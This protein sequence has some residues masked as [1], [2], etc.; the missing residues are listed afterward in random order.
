MQLEPGQGFH[1]VRVHGGV[2]AIAPP[3]PIVLT[4]TPAETLEVLANWLGVTKSSQDPIKRFRWASPQLCCPVGSNLTVAKFKRCPSREPEPAYMVTHH[5]GT[6]PTMWQGALWSAG[7]A[8]EQAN[9]W[10]G[11]VVMQNRVSLNALRVVPVLDY[12]AVDVFAV[13]VVPTSMVPPDVEVP[14]RD[15]PWTLTSED[16]SLQ[17]SVSDGP[18]AEHFASTVVPGV[19]EA[20]YAARLKNDT[21]EIGQRLEEPYDDDAE[22]E[23]DEQ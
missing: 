3:D 12:S 16:P 14:S 11:S 22:D 5:F 8:L 18:I 20:F 10:M 17:L 7:A 6:P 23:D 4:E 1:L 9:A 13:R 19:P 2:T 21:L 15:A